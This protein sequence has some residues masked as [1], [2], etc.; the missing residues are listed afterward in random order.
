MRPATRA[1]SCAAFLSVP[2]T[3]AFDARAAVR[4][5]P[6]DYASIQVGINACASA[7]GSLGWAERA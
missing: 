6:G 4:H 7:A 3:F 1:L 2:F 5:M